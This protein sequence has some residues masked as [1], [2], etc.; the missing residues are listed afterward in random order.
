MGNHAYK[1][2]NSKGNENVYYYQKGAL[3]RALIDGGLVKFE[4]IATKEH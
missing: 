1:K 2:V 3:K 4:I